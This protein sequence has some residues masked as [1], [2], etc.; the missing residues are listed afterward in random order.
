MTSTVSSRDAGNRF[1]NGLG[2][3]GRRGGFTRLSK[4]Q[5]GKRELGKKYERCP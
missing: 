3:L 5:A 2:Y 1:A 4:L